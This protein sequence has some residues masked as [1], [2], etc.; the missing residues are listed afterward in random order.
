MSV[1]VRFARFEQE[2][3][4]FVVLVDYESRQSEVSAH[5][6]RDRLS[7]CLQ[8]NPLEFKCPPPLLGWRTGIAVPHQVYGDWQVAVFRGKADPFPRQRSLE[9]LELL[10]L[11]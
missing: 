1:H 7:R 5:L 6:I 4:N 9:H 11:T 8:A 3:K 10:G 2:R